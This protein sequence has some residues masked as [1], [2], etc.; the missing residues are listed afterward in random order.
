MKR[1]LGIGLFLCGCAAI[2]VT[3]LRSL[4]Q[5]THKFVLP[6]A[7]MLNVTVT[8]VQ[9]DAVNVKVLPTHAEKD[10]VWG[11]IAA[12]YEGCSTVGLNASDLSTS[13]NYVKFDG[14]LNC[15]DFQPVKIGAYAVEPTDA[16]VGLPHAPTEGSTFTMVVLHT[17]QVQPKVTL[18]GQLRQLVQKFTG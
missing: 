11:K 8:K 3:A 2:G 17:A 9:G 1:A 14:Q 13:R 12:Q 7:T 6:A 10:D 16:K 5:E 4:P 18:I 15:P